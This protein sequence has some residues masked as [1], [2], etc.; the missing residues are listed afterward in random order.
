[1]LTK[2]IHKY[3]NGQLSPDESLKLWHKII[4]DREIYNHFKIQL[5]L[6]CYFE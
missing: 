2:Q 1:M 5:M 4:S 3:I 6:Y